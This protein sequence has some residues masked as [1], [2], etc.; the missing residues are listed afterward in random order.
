MFSNP[1]QQQNNGQHALPLGSTP[2][3][4]AKYAEEGIA[5]Q[6]KMGFIMDANRLYVGANWQHLK[7]DEAKKQFSAGGYLF[8]AGFLTLFSSYQDLL[9]AITQPI[10]IGVML[11]A[12]LLMYRVW[13][14]RNRIPTQKGAENN[15]STFQS[16][17]AKHIEE[18]FRANGTVLTVIAAFACA[19]LGIDAF[20][21][22]HAPFSVTLIA[23][24]IT[25]IPCWLFVYLDGV[26]PALR[27]QYEKISPVEV[28]FF[29]TLASLRFQK[30]FSSAAKAGAA[31]EAIYDIY[32][33]HAKALIHLRVAS[34]LQK[35][36]AEDN[37]AHAGDFYDETAALL[38]PSSEQEGATA[39]GA[40]AE[41]EGNDKKQ[42]QQLSKLIELAAKK[43]SSLQKIS[44]SVQKL[45]RRE[46]ASAAREAIVQ[47]MEANGIAIHPGCWFVS[48]IGTA[49]EK[50]LTPSFISELTNLE[51]DSERREK[52]A[53]LA[54][55]KFQD[56]NS[57]NPEAQ[58][59]DAI[60]REI[61]RIAEEKKIPLDTGSEE[62]I[63]HLELLPII[64]G[65]GFEAPSGAE[66][67]GKDAIKQ[68]LKEAFEAAPDRK[69]RLSF[70][71]WLNFEGAINAV[72]NAVQGV[73][74]GLAVLTGIGLSALLGTPFSQMTA[75]LLFSL[76][77]IISS[78][79]FT[80]TTHRKIH[81][82]I[83]H[84]M[85]AD[86][87]RTD[88]AAH[89][90]YTLITGGF[91]GF[92]GWQAG[93]IV[94]YIMF[95]PETITN[96][97]QLMTL[98]PTLNLPMMLIA[99]MV[100]YLNFRMF[101]SF[102]YKFVVQ[103]F[104]KAHIQ[105]TEGYKQSSFTPEAMKPKPERN[106]LFKGIASLIN[107]LL[108][109]VYIAAHF[110]KFLIAYT[111]KGAGQDA[112]GGVLSKAAW[113]FARLS[114]AASVMLMTRTLYHIISEISFLGSAAPTVAALSIPFMLPIFFMIFR[115]GLESFR[116]RW[117]GKDDQA[118]AARTVH[119]A[120]VQMGKT[121]AISDDQPKNSDSGYG[122]A[123]DDADAAPA[124][125]PAA[126]AATV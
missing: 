82:D 70:N 42:A 48:Y 73:Y 94:A 38:A 78:T 102:T 75:I 32:Q 72:F 56:V 54:A 41:P 84:D 91:L 44:G 117:E 114:A 45:E 76:A 43:L 90:A 108:L 116:K 61:S 109:P 101:T 47:T 59:L 21:S 79:Y 86:A 92:L 98:Q 39:G 12:A 93:V 18:N 30:A 6:K 120:P 31:K 15:L 60:Y 62:A 126:A 118:K 107:G 115:S 5:K 23:M 33:E 69:R 81:K 113:L 122:T 25:L 17:L 57:I 66:N 46:A 35:A 16:T 24:A 88:K 105:K 26:E 55:E 13:N 14:E 1:A 52:L 89:L 77:G 85:N 2:I 64:Q 49:L 20:K 34:T 110:S 58:D 36:I 37:T 68:A 27:K 103:D 53:A 3:E 119:L 11:F 7:Q 19:G 95:H 83:I 96:F 29:F 99:G 123:D 87:S 67:P 104:V 50:A 121:V 8:G 51:H 63:D 100:A 65:G 28:K 97:A 71:D 124:A 40:A 22:I 4:R 112:K 74:G 80:W 10:A 111:A 125:A 9:P 106:F